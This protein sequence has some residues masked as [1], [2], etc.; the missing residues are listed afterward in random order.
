MPRTRL[1]PVLLEKLATKT[2]KSPQYIRE[3]ISRR[4]ARL[5]IASEAAMVLWAREFGI[6]T[7]AFQRRLDPHIQQ[8]IGAARFVKLSNDAIPRRTEAK[9]PRDPRGPSPLRASIDFL[10]SD[11]ELKRRC[12]DLLT[13][14]KSFDR[15]FREATVVLDNRLKRLAQIKGKMNPADLVARVLHPDRALLVVSEHRDEQQ[16]FFELVKGLMAAFRNPAHH[17]LNDQSTRE[18]ALRFCGFIDSL[19]SIL[20]RARLNLPPS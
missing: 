9:V 13:A 18:E 10:L 15:V 2:K 5:S 3:Q 16:G 14:R 17:S 11:E 7:A 20:G 8:Q 12:A 1:D 6:G 19:L 4:A